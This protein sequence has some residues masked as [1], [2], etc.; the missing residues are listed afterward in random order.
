MIIKDKTNLL[1]FIED[2][3][4]LIKDGKW[5]EIYGVLNRR[6]GLDLIGDFTSLLLSCGT[7]PLNYMDEVPVGF[8]YENTEIT[9]FIIPDGIKIIQ[10]GAFYE[11]TNLKNIIIPE[12]VVEI[13]NLAFRGCKAL[14]DIILPKKLKDIEHEAFKECTGLRT[15]TIPRSLEFIGV[16]LFNGCNNLTTV[17]YEG[18][19]KEWQN[20]LKRN[21]IT[22]FLMLFLKPVHLEYNVQ[23]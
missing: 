12:S 15:V 18:S 22:H 21:N 5:E 23:Y 7:D 9:R 16:G 13:R 10:A 11:C 2:N 8:L 1:H 4:A 20:L 3:E 19:E 6:G 17:R 14:I